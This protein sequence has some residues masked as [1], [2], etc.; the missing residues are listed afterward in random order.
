MRKSLGGEKGPKVE[1]SNEWF[2][3]MCKRARG[4]LTNALRSKNRSHIARVRK[5]YAS[6]IKKRKALWEEVVWENLPAVAR[7]KD[8][9]R[10]WGLVSKKGRSDAMWPDCRIRSEEWVIYFGG[11]YKTSIPAAGSTVGPLLAPV[12]ERGEYCEEFTLEETTLAI[13]AQKP[14]KAPGLDKIPSDLYRSDL[15]T[16]APYV[17]VVSNALMAGD[18]DTWK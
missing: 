4:A 13:L 17:N 16:P 2:D 1:R 3:H 10:F 18:P 14:G 7:A 9:K 11:L 5:K 12:K 6:T 8:S 15:Q